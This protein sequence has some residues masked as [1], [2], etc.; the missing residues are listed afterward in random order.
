MRWLIAKPK[1]VPPSLFAVKKRIENIR[2]SV[3]RDAAPVVGN[4]DDDVRAA[5]GFGR[6]KRLSVHTTGGYLTGT[7]LTSKWILD[8]KDET[9]YW[10]TADIGWV[11]GHSYVFYICGCASA[12]DGKKAVNKAYNKYLSGFPIF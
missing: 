2:Q 11:T 9:T 10:C 1:P 3:G 6:Q 12:K 7:Y 4:G 8:L 5:Q